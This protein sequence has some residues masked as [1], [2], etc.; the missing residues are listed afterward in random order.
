M[1]S[2]KSAKE[3]QAFNSNASAKSG[4]TLTSPGSP[5]K[6]TEP[7]IGQAYLNAILVH[8]DERKEKK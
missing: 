4:K 7:D 8:N 3:E 5:N 6:K 2:P 1:E